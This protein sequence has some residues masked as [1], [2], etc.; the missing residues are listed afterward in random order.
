MNF[1]GRNQG[2]AGPLRLLLA[3]TIVV[4]AAL[5][6][7][8][9]WLNYRAA[10]AAAQQ[11]LAREAEVG[12]E[13]AAR[14][15]D[16]Q[17]LVAERVGDML[18]GMDEAAI[19]RAQGALHDRFHAIIA[20]L[21]Q[22]RSIYVLSK[23]GRGLVSATVATL[24][25]QVSLA[26]RDYFKALRGGAARYVSEVHR[27]RF[28]KNV[29]FFGLS[30]RRNAPD[31]SFDGVITISVSPD[32][33]ADFDKTLVGETET[34]VSL[35]RNDGYVFVRYPWLDRSKPAAPAPGEFRA[36]I[37]RLPDGGSYA[38]RSLVDQE[39]RLYAYRKVPGY[40]VYVVAGR[41]F[42]AIRHAWRWQM[43]SYLWYGIPVTFALLAITLLALRRT[44]REQA[45]L[46]HAHA[47]MQRREL[48]EQAL[49]QSQ[50][51]EAI[52]Q[53]TGGVAHDFNNLLLV[54]NGNLDML[55]P[56]LTEPSQQGAFEAIE[57]AARR[58]ERLTRQLLSF[59]RRQPLSPKV[60]DLADRL[61]RLRELLSGSLRGDIA[62]AIAV[63]ATIYPVEV[64]PG[65]LELAL[66]NLAVNARDAMPKGGTLTLEAEN[67]M[68]AGAAE[69]HGLAGDFVALRCTDTGEGIAPD[70]LAK[71][72]E[73]FFTTKEV[74]K[75][76][77]LGLSQV[78]GFATQ[79]GGTA[80]VASAPGRG[81]RIT[82]Y[83][84]RSRKP[85]PAPDPAEAAHPA[86]GGKGRILIVE[87]NLQV[88]E[89]ASAQLRAAGYEVA[90]AHDAQAALDRV[91]KEPAFDL[92]FSD[93]VMPGGMSGLDL[94][95]ILAELHPGLPVLL[96]TGYS[97]AS[98]NG[99]AEGFA[100]LPKPYMP[101]A[102]LEAVRE[103]LSAAR[104]V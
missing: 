22:V 66:I 100:I 32:V 20:G 95:H 76:T 48:A 46:A 13:H 64:D 87:D 11:E 101:A 70:Y 96:T 1:F 26:D 17:T 77:G 72:F 61:P 36:S 49:R 7:A 53:L 84:P 40:P 89:V 88:A 55:R 19:R 54:I 59:S 92:V 98:Q 35:I 29:W 90:I 51:L 27:S 39:P 69:T 79:A 43:A 68:L 73:P 9:G 62:I 2:A 85:P 37:L 83:L 28:E 18:H 45:A 99:A 57:L 25:P 97:A 104:Q 102:L 10:F 52:G 58:G 31:G 103:R 30:R 3:A 82:L 56:K 60:V 63:P 33:Y 81:T 34:T 41:R 65:E 78:Y 21:P 24:S 67:V 47:E 4:P 5:F 15:F 86:A 50:K 12:C 16:S 14:V 42:K 75:G 74:G 94:A 6:A 23:E 91:A 8:V 44:R 38:A 93:V 80:T 71:V